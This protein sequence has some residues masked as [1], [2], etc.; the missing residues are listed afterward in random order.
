MACLSYKLL[1]VRDKVISLM[2]LVLRKLHIGTTLYPFKSTVVVATLVQITAKTNIST[3][4]YKKYLE[5]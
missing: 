2:S 5:K 1:K 3:R 4:K